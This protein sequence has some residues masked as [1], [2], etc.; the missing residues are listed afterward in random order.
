MSYLKN[1]VDFNSLSQIIRDCDENDIEFINNFSEQGKQGIV[2]KVCVKGNEC[3]Y[4]ISQYIDYII[5]HEYNI[6]KSLL[7]LREYCPHFCGVY[8]CMNIKVDGRYKTRDNPFEIV[9]KH[10]IRQDV[11][12]MEYVDTPSLYDTI[13]NNKK[14]STNTIIN[15]IKQVIMGVSIA[16][17]DTKFTHYD[18]HSCNIL[19]NECD[20]D[21]VFLYVLDND[22]YFCVPTQGYYPTIIDFGFSYSDELQGKPVMSPLIH[23]NVGFM[24]NQFDQISD[25]KLLLVTISDEIKKYRNSGEGNTLRNITRNLFQPLDIDWECGWDNYVGGGMNE[26]VMSE[27]DN[28]EVESR[29]FK[30]FSNL[31]IDI[32]QSL[33]VLPL[34]QRSKNYIKESYRTIV[35]EFQK[36]EREISSDFFCMYI[37]RCM[38]DAAREVKNI[39]IVSSKRV[40]AITIFQRKVHAACS[41]VASFCKPKGVN[42][43]KLLCSVYVFANCCESLLYDI[44]DVKNIEKQEEYKL[45]ELTS[46]EHIFGAIDVNIPSNYKFNKNTKVYVFDRNTKSRKL[47]R[48]LPD[49]LIRDINISHT[50]IKG[51]IIYEYYTSKI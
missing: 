8:D 49:E 41:D 3:V 4:K 35:T 2:G 1:E 12:L 22:N 11:M 20:K 34:R 43:E 27:I 31:C 5:R 13:K 44:V 9:S 19:L 16:Q 38:I 29:L 33:I 32:V 26:Y 51:S 21:D 50:L 18:L 7:Q 37:F 6:L 40:E 48:D 10:P 25:I 24:S 14:I 39:Y 23:T 28:V 15:T 36:I 47:I 45:L 42:Y 17:R 30:K 46:P